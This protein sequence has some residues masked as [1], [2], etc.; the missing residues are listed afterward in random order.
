[1]FT[2]ANIDVCIEWVCVY[3]YEYM[4]IYVLYIYRILET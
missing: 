3:V 4:Y 1:M 2:F